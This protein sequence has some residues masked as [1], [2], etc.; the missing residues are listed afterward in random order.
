MKAEDLRIGNLVLYKGIVSTV[1][2]ISN[3][4]SC[5]VRFYKTPL[6]IIE[7]SVLFG[8]D[9]NESEPIKLTEEW[10]LKLGG[11]PVIGNEFT[12]GFITVEFDKQGCYY[13]AGEGLWLSKNIEYVHELQNIHHALSGKELTLINN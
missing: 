6:Q 5:Y 8:W 10:I 3:D 12:I 1:I 4:N 13:T 9:L 11:K 2:K 7:E